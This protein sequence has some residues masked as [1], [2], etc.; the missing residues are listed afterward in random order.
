[1]KA[2]GDWRVMLYLN[3]QNAPHLHTMSDYSRKEDYRHLCDF[4]HKG[5]YPVEEK[6][7]DN[8][9][10]RRQ[11]RTITEVSLFPKNSLY[12]SYPFFPP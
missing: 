9:G 7:G 10:K 12:L 11:R 5:D 4:A 1:M 2:G 3:L 8:E 6:I